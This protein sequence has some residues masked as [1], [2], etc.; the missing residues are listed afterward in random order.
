MINIT[1]ASLQ[2]L[3]LYGSSPLISRSFHDFNIK[4]SYF[5]KS[6]ISVLNLHTFSHLSLHNSQFTKFSMTPIHISGLDFRNQSFTNHT[7]WSNETTVSLT[8]CL[9]LNCKSSNSHGGAILMAVQGQ[10]SL[11][12]NCSGFANCSTSYGDGGAIYC[13]TQNITLLKTCFQNCFCANKGEVLHLT[14]LFEVNLNY[15]EINN[16]ETFK[17]VNRKESTLV[18]TNGKLK[19]IYNTI[20]ISNSVFQEGIEF[21][22]HITEVSFLSAINVHCNSLLT[23]ANTALLLSNC[24]IINSTSSES[25]LNSKHSLI[26]I[27]DSYF[28][29]ITDT[30]VEFDAKTSIQFS[31]VFVDAHA[32]LG[33]ISMTEGLYI[34]NGDSTAFNQVK[35]NTDYCWLGQA[36]WDTSK[37]KFKLSGA[38]ISFAV[39]CFIVLCIYIYLK[40]KINQPL[41]D[42]DIHPKRR[43]S[44]DWNEIEEPDEEEILVINEEHPE[45]EE[46]ESTDKLNIQP[47]EKGSLNDNDDG[48]DGEIKLEDIK[49]EQTGPK[50]K[51]NNN[52]DNSNTYN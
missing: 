9:F 46:K 13:N 41:T 48:E 17:D 6:T 1:L 10:S 43:K 37:I 30:L 22:S 34:N 8:K 12:I 26:L 51:S 7:S 33:N 36:T 16:N 27:V 49:V 15:I 24:D 35:L 29:G 42:D 28:S 3:N 11:S 5:S 52:N 31:N 19:N 2:L 32:N 4:N 25:F 14:T 23:I 50:P 38:S 39:I 40:N 20:N 18:Y 45:E 21:I 44:S 47:S